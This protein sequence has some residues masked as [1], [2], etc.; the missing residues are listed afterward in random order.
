MIQLNKNA[1]GLVP[2]DQVVLFG[3]LPPGARE[4]PRHVMGQPRDLDW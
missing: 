3:L 1:F 4:L 2:A